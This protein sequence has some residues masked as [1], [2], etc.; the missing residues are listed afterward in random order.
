[1]EKISKYCEECLKFRQK[2][3]KGKKPLPETV[4][5]FGGRQGGR[6]LR[7]G[8]NFCKLYEFDE[9]LYEFADSSKEVGTIHTVRKRQV[10]R[11]E[12]NFNQEAFDDFDLG[13]SLSSVDF[14]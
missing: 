2:T 5:Y 14:E 7:A 11:D 6:K 3:C 9:Q 12:E 10:K 8:L 4:L 1:M 13:A